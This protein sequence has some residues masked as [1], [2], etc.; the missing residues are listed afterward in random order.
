MTSFRVVEHNSFDEFLGLSRDRLQIGPIDVANPLRGA[1]D[2]KLE[3]WPVV[4]TLN[5]KKEIYIGETR[6]AISR[7]RQHHQNE[8]KRRLDKLHIIIDKTFNKS[9]ALDLESYLIRLFSGE[10]KFTVLNRN[11]GIVDSDYFNRDRY[12]GVFDEI[13]DELRSRGFFTRS[14]AEIQNLDLYKFSPFKAPT[15]EQAIIGA[16]IVEQF[17]ADRRGR[18]QGEEVVQGGAGTGKT[19]LAIYLLKLLRDIER[20]D[21]SEELDSDTMFS[22]FFTGEHKELLT[23]FTAGLV[24]PQQSLRESVKKVFQNTPDLGDTHILS[25]FDVGETDGTYDLLIVD[26]AHRLN[27]RANQPSGM[28]NKRFKQI[29][30]SLFGKDQ[31]ELTQ[32]DWIR[33]KSHHRVLMIDHNQTVRP[34]DINKRTVGELV[35]SAKK[36][37]RYFVLET[38]MRVKAGTDYPEF[39]R[40]LLD[41]SL[42][43]VTPDLGKEYEF[44][45]FTDLAKMRE[46]IRRRDEKYDLSRMVAGFAWG[47]KSKA[48]R[49]LFDIEE[50]G[51]RLRWNSTAKDW[52]NAE[53]SVNEV[54]SIHTV[55]G[56]DLNYAGVII[57]RDL[58]M[59]PT[60]GEVIF[61]RKNYFDKKGM[62]NNPRRGIKYSNEDILAYVKN[63]YAVLL[64]RGIR[65]TFIYVCD[66]PLRE[67]F[68]RHL[69]HLGA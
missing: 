38:Q 22:E 37:E 59:D 7:L 6:N 69:P 54:G 61:D 29:N 66:E 24:I 10:G 16:G 3:N 53:D 15:A 21:L 30:E 47:W 56:Y 18:V 35:D 9:A 36:N 13:F 40:Q 64:S 63:I 8:E 33:Q 25:P 50:D 65:G 68:L 49:S 58:R 1:S 32:L 28:Q 46:A 42:T 14:I 34:A 51:L 67:Y 45:V 39:I 12:Q 23:G 48:D 20:R 43:S 31:D 52:I 44:G 57:G 19:V 60:T 4:Y 27:Q 5:N 17:L 2:T 11:D 41:G 55:Q 62:E 26:E